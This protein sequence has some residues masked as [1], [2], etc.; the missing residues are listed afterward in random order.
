MCLRVDFVHTYEV[1]DYNRKNKSKTT[2]VWELG[3]VTFENVCGL[4]CVCVYILEYAHTQIL[5]ACVCG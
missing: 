4:V 2:R 5:R 3:G 1:V